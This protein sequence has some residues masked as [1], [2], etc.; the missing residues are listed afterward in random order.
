MVGREKPSLFLD[1]IDTIA[2]AIHRVRRDWQRDDIAA[3]FY[4]SG[5]PRETLLQ[6]L[7]TSCRSVGPDGAYLLDRPEDVLSG[8]WLVAAQAKIDQLDA[9]DRD[10]HTHGGE[11]DKQ[12]ADHILAQRSPCDDG[13]DGA[14][15]W[16]S[17]I[18]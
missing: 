1:P 9:R 5:I 8:N 11:V 13:F 7:A 3:L 6:A 2:S 14:S 18:L 4:Q 17:T 12:A 10:S 16:G 15:T